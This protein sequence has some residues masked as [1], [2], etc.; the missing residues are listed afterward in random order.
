ML[1]EFCQT[2]LADGLID[3]L[4]YW[5]DG[6]STSIAS[7]KCSSPYHSVRPSLLTTPLLLAVMC[8]VG[9]G[10]AW[11]QNRKERTR[12]GDKQNSN[13]VFVII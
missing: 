9:F 5:N 12:R 4:F 6:W 10:H 2:R 13:G 8:Y 3:E 11:L 7:S 1:Q